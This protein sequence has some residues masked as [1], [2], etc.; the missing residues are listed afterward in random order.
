MRAGGA[1]ET[2]EQS[3]KETM[4]PGFYGIRRRVSPR[5]ALIGATH[6]LGSCFPCSD[7]TSRPCGLTSL[8]WRCYL[9]D[10][11][12]SIS[13]SPSLSRCVYVCVL[14][15]PSLQFPFTPSQRFD[16]R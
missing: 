4:P 5:R 14:L 7:P 8:R 12:L 9:L 10:D 1:H 11:V 16:E 6:V 3:S 15:F 13:L 2:A